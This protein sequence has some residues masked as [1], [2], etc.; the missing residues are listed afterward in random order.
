MIVRDEE[1]LIGRI[2]GDASGVCDELVVID[3]G[4]TDNTRAIA[5]ERGAQVHEIVWRED[6]ATARNAS[7][8]WCTCPWILWLDA[9]DILPHQTKE[10]IMG[11][12][13]WLHDDVDVVMSPY[14]YIIDANDT[15]LLS[16]VRE[17]LIRRESGLR[18]VGRIHEAIPL[19]GARSVLV[20]DLVVEH[21]PA[22]ERRAL[23][24]D[25]NLRSLERQVSSG[26]P[27][28]RTLFYYANELYDHGRYQE[29]AN[30]YRGY[31]DADR[32][33]SPDRYW[34]HVYLAESAR[35]LGEEDGMREEAMRAIAEDPSRA[36][37]YMTLG[38]LFFDREEWDKAMPLFVAATSVVLPTLG[39]VRTVDYA[40]APWDFLSVCLDRLGRRSEAL[41]AAQK[42]LQGNPE[43]ERIR[44]NMRWMVENL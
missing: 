40:Y 2:L 29:A 44:S 32:R 3:T 8:A 9:D 25:R 30:A 10:T 15:V 6:F 39:F 22:A 26:H 28:P 18:W 23:N 24:A 5:R 12:K 13:G 42:A 31:L 7:L 4:S 16:V 17:R 19:E 35:A 20:P 27:E 34:A 43:K 21:R 36:E 14:H 1:R 37:G 41:V 38:R 11:L 33:M